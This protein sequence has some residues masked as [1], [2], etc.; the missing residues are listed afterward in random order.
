[1]S[2]AHR[3]V[4]LDRKS[5]ILRLQVPLGDYVEIHHQDRVVRVSIEEIVERDF[6]CSAIHSRRRLRGCHMKVSNGGGLLFCGKDCEEAD[7]NEFIVPTKEF[8]L[9]EPVSVYFF[10]TSTGLHRFFR[11]FVEH[12]NRNT[13]V[14][15]LNAFLSH[16]EV[17]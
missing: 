17:C 10:W 7:T 13:G 3:T 4:R 12:I 11:L 16:A 6:L 8:D 5:G 2:S 15:T 1:M 14:V 9:E